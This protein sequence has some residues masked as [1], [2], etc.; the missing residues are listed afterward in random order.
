MAFVLTDPPVS[1]RDA[2][3]VGDA[4]RFARL[5]LVDVAGDA[6]RAAARLQDEDEDEAAPRSAA[7]GGL[8]SPPSRPGRRV[9]L[10]LHPGFSAPSPA[11]R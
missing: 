4:Q 7:Q 1:A 5:Y 8:A 2:R 9:E 10:P 11:A 6:A 3:V